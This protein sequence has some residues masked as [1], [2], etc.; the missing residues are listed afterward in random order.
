MR[1]CLILFAVCAKSMLARKKAEAKNGPTLCQ[2]Q[3]RKG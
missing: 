3:N 1:L 2:K